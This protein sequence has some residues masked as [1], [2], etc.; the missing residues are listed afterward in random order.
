MK[1]TSLM[2]WAE[3]ADSVAESGELANRAG[4]VAS[5]AGELRQ[6]AAAVKNLPVVDAQDA[7]G[8][9]NEGGELEN[10]IGP[11]AVLA[12]IPCEFSAGGEHLQMIGA[13][14]AGAVGN[15]G[16]E[17]MDRLGPTSICPPPAH[18]GSVSGGLLGG[19][20][21]CYAPARSVAVARLPASAVC[22][23]GGAW[24]RA[25]PAIAGTCL[26]PPSRL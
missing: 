11:V 12:C 5:L 4:A 1:R 21:E 25:E 14:D 20:R 3:H 6:E 26:S 23:M 19:G 17:L 10:R 8:I 2:V 16:C 22:G 24:E 9:R 13:E 7:G 18:I 15:Q